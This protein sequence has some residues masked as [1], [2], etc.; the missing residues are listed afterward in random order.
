MSC[1]L[2]GGVESPEQLWE[3]VMA[4][5]DAISDLPGDRGWEAVERLAELGVD[6][7][8]GRWIRKG[9]F[10]DSAA[11]F[12]AGFFG[13]SAEEALAMDPQQ[14]L[15]LEMSWEAIERAGI[16]PRTMRGSGTGVYVGTFYQAYWAGPDG[17]AED[18]KPFLG[19]G[20][21][22]MF[23]S[24]R[25]AYALGLEGP[26]LT[27]D[28]G[29][30]SSGVALHLACQAVR[31]GDCSSALVGGV[32]V[33]SSPMGMPDH[34]GIA[35]DGRCRAF[36]ADADG[37]GWG[38]GAAMVMI[39][40]LSEA[41]R[42]GHPVLAVIRGSAVN[43]N[44]ASNGLSAPNGPSQQRLIRQAL[45]NAGLSA[46]EVDAV[47]THSTGSPLGDAIEAQALLAAYGQD[48]P[49]DRPVRL[50]T[51]KSNI[52]HSQAASGLVGVIKMVMAIRRGVLPKTLY[53][54]SR[55][56]RTDWDSGAV[57]LLTETVP[58][59]DTGRPRRAAVSS[60]GASGTKAHIILEQDTPPLPFAD[61]TSAIT[62]ASEHHRAGPVPVLVSSR[63]R[64]GLWEQARRL[65]EFMEDHPET[66]PHDLAWSLA[67]TRSAFEHRAVLFA[68]D[69]DELLAALA[70]VQRGEAPEQ[71]VGGRAATD[72]RTGLLFTGITNLTGFT[73]QGARS[74]GAE[75]RRKGA[76]KELYDRFP[77]FAD[78]LDEACA[79]LDAAYA[80]LES[81]TRDIALGL[82]PDGVTPDPVVTRAASFAHEVAS[83]ALLHQL[84]LEP[85]VSAGQGLGLIAAVH[86]AGTLT[87]E[88]AATLVVAA[89]RLPKAAGP[90]AEEE[91]R[92]AVKHVRL[93][94]ARLPCVFAPTGEPLVYERL[95]TPGYWSRERETD[96]TQE[97][98]KAAIG[99]LA[100]SVALT[101]AEPAALNEGLRP[102]DG[103]LRAIAQAHVSGAPVAW[104][105]TL[106][107]LGVPAVPVEL[108]TY[109]FRRDRYWLKANPVAMFG[110]ALVAKNASG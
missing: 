9:G 21:S 10:I 16:D 40:R 69:R 94:P 7:A 100:G 77:A 12:D 86:A 102:G 47:E 105:R 90:A 52:G 33:L 88:D 46:D 79:C 67:T 38:E 66:G 42:L 60:F 35:S 2:P 91:F 8:G 80:G 30:S 28:T 97:T 72:T 74:L 61:Q 26:S 57:S 81:P 18:V 87:L 15:L 101:R 51:V 103:V 84:G 108:P 31:R 99:A 29:C 92:R 53:A 43:N 71:M 85:E 64:D 50:G 27:T 95:L 24:G 36:S 96:E 58:W 110:N 109:A 82:D 83:G 106:S 13:I 1:R 63:S 23:A 45:A 22:P 48:R 14:R 54:E 55:S 34:G 93:H 59:P 4:G 75:S 78:A 62:P 17:I 6:L 44:G 19:T 98:H 39:E 73:E 70:A 56:P 104:R 49:A 32:T 65:K 68:E 11:E 37:T 89:G 76:A 5:R 107:A 25:I 41:R 20:V 3:L